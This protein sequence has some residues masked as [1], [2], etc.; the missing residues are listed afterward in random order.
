MHN[1]RY[2]VQEA[3]RDVREN[4]KQALGS[5]ALVL[6]HIKLADIYEGEPPIPAEIERREVAFSVIN[7]GKSFNGLTAFGVTPESVGINVD[8]PNDDDERAILFITD[9]DQPSSLDEAS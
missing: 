8:I 7:M 5:A 9:F 1:R 3:V 4:C 6:L 2:E